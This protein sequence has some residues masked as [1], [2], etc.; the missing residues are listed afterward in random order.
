MVSVTL[1][2]N[3]I[4][5]Q[6][7][8]ATK[9]TNKI[10]RELLNSATTAEQQQPLQA[11]W[12]TFRWDWFCTPLIC[13]FFLPMSMCIYRAVDR[14]THK[15]EKTGLCTECGSVCIADLGA[16]TPRTTRKER[17]TPLDI[18]TVNGADSY[19]THWVW[20]VLAYIWNGLLWW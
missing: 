1:K 20:L 9:Y 5:R 12:I 13:S 14:K 16:E 11:I 10:A 15:V 17:V 4:G 8:G 7:I 3:Q 2:F 6:Q 18:Y 19:S